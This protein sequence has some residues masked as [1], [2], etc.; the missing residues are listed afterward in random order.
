MHTIELLEQALQTAEAIG[1]GIRHE[2]L[3]GCGGTCEVAGKKWLF[4]DLSQDTSE[5]LDTTV[6]A[7]KQD[8]A[9]HGLPMSAELR[10]LL[11]LRKRV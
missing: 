6:E 10:D 3:G 4:V 1:Y 8:P 2:W 11:G 7:L 9:V 5:Q